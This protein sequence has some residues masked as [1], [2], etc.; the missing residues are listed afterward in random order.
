MVTGILARRWRDLLTSVP[1]GLSVLNKGFYEVTCHKTI[2]LFRNSEKDFLSIS[3][4]LSFWKC[5]FCIFVVQLRVCSKAMSIFVKV[6]SILGSYTSNNMTQHE[7]ARHNTR[8]LDTTQGNTSTTRHNTRQHKC[9]TKQHKYNTTQHETT[10]VQHEC[11][12]RQH[13]YNT[14]QHEYKTIQNLFWFIHIIVACS[15]TGILGSK[16]L[17]I[18]QNLENWKS[19]FPLTVK[20]ELENIKAAV[21][22]NCVFVFLFIKII[23]IVFFFQFETS[24]EKAVGVNVNY[25]KIFLRVTYCRKKSFKLVIS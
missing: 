25:S 12:T 11:N 6:G 9:N 19:V 1:F 8:Q 3:K 23:L 2:L 24:Y 13:E 4:R 21:C 5:I 7:T 15:G 16:A 10:R 20:I 22:C 14:R 18:V 17:F